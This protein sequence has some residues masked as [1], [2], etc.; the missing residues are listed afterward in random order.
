MLHKVI[1][2]LETKFTR[3]NTEQEKFQLVNYIT[4]EKGGKQ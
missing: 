1:G 4:L 3:A 2:E